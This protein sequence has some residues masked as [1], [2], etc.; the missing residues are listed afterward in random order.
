M[1]AGLPHFSTGYMRLWG[2]D[3]FI[4]L[5]GLLIRPGRYQVRVLLIKYVIVFKLPPRLGRS[6]SNPWFRFLDETRINSK[7]V[8]SRVQSQV[9]TVTN[10]LVSI[11]MCAM[12][13]YN[14]RDAVWWWLA[15]VQDYCHH[16]PDGVEFLKTSLFRLFPWDDY[17]N[18]NTPS[19]TKVT[20]VDL[21]QEAMQRHA[22]G[23][24]FRER[25]AG[26]KI[27]DKMTDEG[28]NV[29]VSLDPETGFISGGNKMNCGTWMDK[30]GDSQ[31]A[32]NFG[33]PATSR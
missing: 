30:M 25:N 21:I 27:D 31:K 29:S 5:N 10:V 13:R 3:T 16:A 14:C 33:L 20:L 19:T 12:F 28:F 17:D 7:L 11:L 9:M 18:S 15:S 2:R 1:A 32:K 4:A 26:N 24:Y 6:R 8:R 23:I 22:T